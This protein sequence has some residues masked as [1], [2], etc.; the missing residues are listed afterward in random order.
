MSKSLPDTERP[1]DEKFVCNMR[2]TIP[3]V[4]L[5]YRFWPSSDPD[6]PELTDTSLL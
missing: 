6:G 3:C 1:A 4:D 2:T 5:N